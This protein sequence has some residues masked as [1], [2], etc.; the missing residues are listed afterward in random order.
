MK[1]LQDYQ[2]EKQSALFERLGAFFA[3]SN[4]QFNEA[5]K[6][7]VKY[8]N[9][10]AGLICPKENAAELMKELADIHKA[11]I[12]QDLEENGKEAIILREL[13]NHECFYTGDYS[14]C[15]EKLK[16]YPGITP[17]DIKKAYIKELYKETA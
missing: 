17:E 14:D 15:V 2:E 1:F 12:K 4:E 8:Y 9:C 11:A 3:F 6:P 7:N 10:G 16:L 13:Y 5:K